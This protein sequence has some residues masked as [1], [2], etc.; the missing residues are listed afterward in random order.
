MR[1][2][3]R[4]YTVRTPYARCKSPRKSVEIPCKSVVIHGISTDLDGLTRTF[5]TCIRCPHGAN[6]THVEVRIFMDHFPYVRSWSHT[7]RSNNAAL[8]YYS[9]LYGSWI[10]FCSFN[11]H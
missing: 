6:T 4:I 10:Y 2:S 7:F 8:G 11:L 9:E 3:S 1:G 5:A